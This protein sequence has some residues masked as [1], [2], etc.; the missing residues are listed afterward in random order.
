MIEG[1]LQPSHLLIILVVALFIF[2]PKKLPELGQGLGKGIR[3][4][5]DSMK[6]ATE[7]PEKTETPATK[8][9]DPDQ[10]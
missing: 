9:A 2:G 6:A 10:K 1:L 8:P 5:R 7:E 4:F 3:S